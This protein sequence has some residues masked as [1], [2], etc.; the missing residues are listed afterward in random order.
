VSAA[1]A[2]GLGVAIGLVFMTAWMRWW[3]QN[4]FASTPKGV[5]RHLRKTG[6]VRLRHVKTTDGIWNPSRPLGLDNRLY[7]PGEATYSLD[8]PATVTLEF[9]AKDGQVTR[10]SGPIPETIIHPSE[11]VERARNLFRW[12]LVGYFAIVL[13]GFGIGWVVG[14]G[15]PL[16][17]LIAGVIGMLIAMALM[18]FAALVIRVGHSIRSLAKDKQAPT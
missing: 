10:Y 9:R 8:D 17:R 4:V 15:S 3:M 6:S 1:A 14:G 12:V 7:G 5:L 18:W 16:H 13:I 2:I 11:K